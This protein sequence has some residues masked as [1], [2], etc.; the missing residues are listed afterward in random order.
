VYMFINKLRSQE[1]REYIYQELKNKKLLDFDNLTKGKAMNTAKSMADRLRY[2]YK[3]EDID[4]IL[5]YPYD[6]QEMDSEDIKMRLEML[7]PDNMIAIYH[8]QLLKSEKE[9]SP[10]M[11][12]TE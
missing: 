1:V 11:F 10:E 8:S 4:D 3:E 5:F 6:Y 12:K 2:I 9:S 7:T